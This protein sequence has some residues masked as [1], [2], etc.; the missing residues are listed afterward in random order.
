MLLALAVVWACE[1]FA[2]TPVALTPAQQQAIMDS[3]TQFGQG[4][5]SIGAGTI[6]ATGAA[7]GIPN[8]NAASTGLAPGA[9]GLTGPA[10]AKQAGCN[11]Y[12]AP[13][14]T[15]QVANQQDCDAVNFL[16]KNPNPKA[17]YPINPKTDP[18]ILAGKSIL[19]SARNGTAFPPGGGTPGSGDT[20][21]PNGC[22]TTNPSTPAITT[23]QTCYIA[24][25][26]PS[27][28]CDKTLS[29]SVTPPAGISAIV[30]SIYPQSS[31]IPTLSSSQTGSTY[32]AIVNGAWGSVTAQ[33]PVGWTFQTLTA[34]NNSKINGCV[35]SGGVTYPPNS[36]IPV[37]NQIWSYLLY[38]NGTW[39]SV[40]GQS[41]PIGWTL[42]K[43]T[44]WNN[45]TVVGCVGGG[46]VVYP[47]NSSIPT[48]AFAALTY[49]NGA[50]TSANGQACPSGWAFQT[51]SCPSPGVC[52]ISGCVGSGD[53]STTY[54][55]PAG[56]T[57]S[58]TS[59]IANPV[60]TCTWTDGCT[61]LQ[62][63]TL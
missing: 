57:L 48:L 32:S 2:G 42:Q 30:N 47:V 56:Y 62:A 14:G 28:T 37:S 58:G 59:C 36:V 9:A 49:V 20:T 26:A 5:L 6:N 40:G 41:C 55:C 10:T 23:T 21:V 8:Y 38:V 61:A 15:N 54:S 53:L 16:T 17:A 1:V 43:V 31:A 39:T 34:W 7:A 52:S 18:T 11:N 25:T 45:S 19:D 12:V 51:L 35:G 24:S 29:C 60:A 4:T 13:A 46:N 22:V 3:G 63:K 27:Q 50:L 44:A 33:C